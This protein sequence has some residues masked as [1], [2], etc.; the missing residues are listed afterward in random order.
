MRRED[1][2]SCLG[3]H[4]QKPREV[5][6]RLEQLYGDVPRIELF[7]RESIEGWDLYGNESP[8]NNIEFINGVK[9]GAN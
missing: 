7:A 8:V 4:S 2:Y 1:I 5:H 9:Y 6:Y 3:E